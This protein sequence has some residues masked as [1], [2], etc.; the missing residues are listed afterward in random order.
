MRNVNCRECLADGITVGAAVAKIAQKGF[1]A[2]VIVENQ[3][4]DITLDRSAEIDGGHGLTI[5]RSVRQRPPS[6]VSSGRAD[7]GEDGVRDFAPF[8]IS[9]AADEC[10][11]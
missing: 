5:G 2:A 8:D 10:I 1:E 6:N 9:M 7:R 4:N 3:L 11:G